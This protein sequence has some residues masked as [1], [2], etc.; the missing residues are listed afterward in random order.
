M[1]KEKIMIPF[2]RL[3]LIS[4]KN[5]IPTPK[6]LDFIKKCADGGITSLQLREKLLSQEELLDLGEQL[7]KILTPYHIPLVINDCSTIAQQRT[8]PYIHIGQ[9]DDSI[10]K[11]L[12]KFP[13]GHI[14]VSIESL[15]NLH[16]AN[17]ENNLSY[18]T[19]SAVF[20][21]QNKSNL[22]TIWG[23]NGLKLLSSIS[24]HPITAIGRITLQNTTSIIQHGAHGIALIG[25]IHDAKDPY[26]TTKEFRTLL[27]DLLQE[28]I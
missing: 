13:K 2:Y 24:K 18:V 3:M 23:L 26:Q 27:D 8:T 17:K 1:L 16:S 20:P 21:S 6:Y 22:S 5:N 25:A 7:L 28:Q 14:G 12:T 15:E 19:A 9:K 4:Q 10:Q 11:V